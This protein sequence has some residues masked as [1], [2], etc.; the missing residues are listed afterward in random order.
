MTCLRMSRRP[1][2][3]SSLKNKRIVIGITGSVAA[4]KAVD[5]IR[6][7]KDEEA[8]V[9]VVMTDASKR[10]ITPLSLSIASGGKVYEG[11]FDDPLAHIALAAE[12]E[13]AIIA[14]ATANIIAKLAHG[15]ADDMLS[16]FLV[17]FQ[18]RI[19]IAPAMN[20]RMYENPVVQAN[21]ELL[22]RR[23]VIEVTPECGSLA[24]GE[25]GRGRLASIE[26]IMEAAK[27]ASHEQDCIGKK[28]VV[29]A[30][31]TREYLDA[32]RFISNRSSGKMGYAVARAAARRGADVV[33]ISGPSALSA[34]HNVRTIN[35]VSAS[36]M[37]AAVKEEIK[38]A[39]ALVMAAAVADFRPEGGGHTAEKLGK[40]EI[41][42][43]RLTLNPDILADVGRMRK[44]PVLVGFAANTSIER[45]REKYIKKG[46]DM[47]VYNDIS[48]P[49]AGF[50]VDTNRITIIDAEG[51][52]Q[53][54]LMSKDDV[55]D[56]ILNRLTSNK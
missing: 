2:R 27:A 54:P 25:E 14:P 5:L 37:H 1:P 7:L 51:D 24:C 50:D 4:Y 19:V 40:S 52:T 46:A 48:D 49:E 17:A 21:L 16:T 9:T 34:P 31:P 8:S 22:R 43:I 42:E 15:I 26:D 13:V 10:F 20:W 28:I 23:G 35:V 29:T 32:V 3:K 36:E 47:I 41:R 33:L 6:R 11:L 55:A 30:G 45:A 56:V 53:C 12:A 39:Y 38:G 18:G 44:R